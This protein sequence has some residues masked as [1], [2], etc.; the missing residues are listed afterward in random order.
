MVQIIVLIGTGVTCVYRFAK[1]EINFD[2]D[3]ACRLLK[4]A[5]PI[6]GAGVFSSMIFQSDTVMLSLMTDD[7]S[8]GQYSAA[9]RLVTGT[10]FIP[11]IYVASVLPALSR[12]YIHSKETLALVHAKSVQFL[13]WMALPL[14]TGITLVAS[15]LMGMIYGQ[16]Y[17]SAAPVLALLGWAVACIYI[18]VFF[19]HL[20]VSIEKQATAM[21][22][23]GL[24][25]LVN[26][27]LNL[28]F[29]PVWGITGAAIAGVISQFMI[30]SVQAVV[31]HK[32]GYAIS[33]LIA[34]QKPLLAVSIMASV[35]LIM[36]QVL[37]NSPFATF[38][39][40]FVAAVIYGA[41]I[42]HL[43]GEEN[44]KPLWTSLR[45]P[46]LSPE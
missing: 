33:W 28:V 9:M 29:I 32:S 2:T 46:D 38:M 44:M 40:I 34:I 30:V 36:N 13:I 17:A 20:L 4:T 24:A 39:I 10:L 43:E 26:V 1:P 42:W 15:R 8:V 41:L 7:S 22:I 3:L 18:G 16:E 27:I 19:S 21:K 31:L 23:V 25:A 12:L 5:L 45:R 11:G 37:E 14:A 35:V 6:A